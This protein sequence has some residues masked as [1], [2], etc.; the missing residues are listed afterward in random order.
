MRLL[1]HER[2]YAR[3]RAAIEAHGA[4]LEPV[5]INDAGEISFGGQ[6]VSTEE[7]RPDIAW[8][9]QDTFF[10]GAGRNFMAAALKSPNAIAAEAR[11]LGLVME[12]ERSFVVKHLPH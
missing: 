12:G 2:S 7:A 10:S 4:A 11:R 6:A 5:T 9:N 3:N 8:A 1:I